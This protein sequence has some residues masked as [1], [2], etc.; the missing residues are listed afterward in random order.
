MF[1][2]PL[3]LAIQRFKARSGT[4]WNASLPGSGDE[5]SDSPLWLRQF[6]GSQG[7]RSQRPIQSGDCAR[8]RR[9][10]PRPGG[11][12]FLSALFAR[13]SSRPLR[14]AKKLTADGAGGRGSRPGRAAGFCF[15]RVI[16]VIRGSL[17]C[18]WIASRAAVNPLRGESS[19]GSNRKERRERRELA[20]VTLA[21]SPGF[22][23]WD[24][25]QSERAGLCD[26]L[27]TEDGTPGGVLE[28][29]QAR[30]E[31]LWKKQVKPQMDT[32]GHRSEGVAERTDATPEVNR[33]LGIDLCLSVS[34]CGFPCFLESQLTDV[35]SP[36]WLRRFAGSRDSPS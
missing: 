12:P 9:R 31:S 5:R 21:R 22:G 3:A 33:F 26:A 15:I 34:I 25:G 17:G 2:S 4:R 8:L 24:A 29:G 19:G 7:S 23:R 13:R 14:V 6:A 10:S 18:G 11:W 1:P 30:C 35:G 28:C 27:P 32:D 16:R 20:A 36:L